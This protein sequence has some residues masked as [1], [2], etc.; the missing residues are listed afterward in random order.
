MY[1]NSYS[2]LLLRFLSLKQNTLMSSA[3][4]HG[5]NLEK[6]PKNYQRIEMKNVAHL[7]PFEKPEELARMIIDQGL[8][9]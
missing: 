1:G 9:V 2:T 5:K 8:L 3:K 7:I 4:R 6:L